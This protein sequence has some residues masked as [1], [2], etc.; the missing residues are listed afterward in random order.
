VAAAAAADALAAT[1]AEERGC[2]GRLAASSE[3]ATWAE[4]EARKLEAACSRA[5]AALEALRLRCQTGKEALREVRG[6]PLQAT[7]TGRERT[8]P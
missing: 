4:A 3:A 2:C 1:R 5:G 7:Q 6:A 8:M